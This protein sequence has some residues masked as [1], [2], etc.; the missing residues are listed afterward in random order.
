MMGSL[1]EHAKLPC[2][3]IGF[4]VNIKADTCLQ[5]LCL[6]TGNYSPFLAVL[7]HRLLSSYKYFLWIVTK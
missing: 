3:T 7:S 5:K 4:S 2:A 6:R 1:N